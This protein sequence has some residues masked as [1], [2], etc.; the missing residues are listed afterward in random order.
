MVSKNI[1][2]LLSHY[3][4]INTPLVH[5]T[6]NLRTICKRYSLNSLYHDIAENSFYGTSLQKILY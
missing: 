1:L 2:F 3:L 6:Y 4:L 5:N